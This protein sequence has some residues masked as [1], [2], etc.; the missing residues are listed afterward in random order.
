MSRSKSA[1]IC[2]VMIRVMEFFL[3]WA[4][5]LKYAII[6]LQV[7]FRSNHDHGQWSWRWPMTTH[8]EKER[9]M[10]GTYG[11]NLGTSGMN[12]E[13]G[14][15]QWD[16]G[17][18]LPSRDATSVQKDVPGMPKGTPLP[19]KMMSRLPALV[20]TMRIQIWSSYYTHFQ[21]ASFPSM[22]LFELCSF[23]IIWI[24]FHC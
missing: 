15:G 14:M 18:P 23:L 4:N 12:S 9:D 16:I 6:K 1:L 2:H 10:T 24:R 19:P 8:Q 13:G 21:C 17:A 11:I 3:L 5:S 22:K 7:R 20:V